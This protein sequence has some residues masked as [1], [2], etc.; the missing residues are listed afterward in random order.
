MGIRQKLQEN[1]KLGISLG[2]ILLV[3]AI[4]FIGFQL[5]G[6]SGHIV[7][8]PAQG[9][10]TDDNGKTFFKDDANKIVPFDHNGKQAYRCDVFEG[11]DGKQFVGLIYRH[12]SSGR[13]EMQDYIERKLYEND[14]DALIRQGIESR[15]SDV[16]RAGADDRAWSRNDDQK[17]EHLRATMKTPSG[18]PARLVIP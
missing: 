9:F 16:K 12:N 14:I 18:E 10:Y 15:G 1:A 3:I 7:H 8:A 2:A 11:P 6:G 5:H 4:G 17:T 13:L